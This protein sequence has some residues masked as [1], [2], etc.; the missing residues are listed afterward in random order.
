MMRRGTTVAHLPCLRELLGGV[1]IAMSVSGNYSAAW[2]TDH[3]HVHDVRRAPGRGRLGTAPR[4]D[5]ERAGRRHDYSSLPVPEPIAEVP[6]DVV[7]TLVARTKVV[8]ARA[9]KAIGRL[10]VRSARWIRLRRWL[11]STAESLCSPA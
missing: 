1:F 8:T 9:V 3:G 2:L 11:S 7:G 10:H 6:A 4:L 5:S